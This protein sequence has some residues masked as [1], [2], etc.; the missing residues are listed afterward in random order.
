LSVNDLVYVLNKLQINEHLYD[1]LSIVYKSYG[2]FYPKNLE[3]AIKIIDKLQLDLKETLKQDIVSPSSPLLNHSFHPPKKRE[4]AVRRLITESKKEGRLEFFRNLAKHAAK[5][6]VIDN[7]PFENHETALYVA[8]K[9]SQFAKAII[10]LEEGATDI[11]SSSGDKPSMLANRIA[12]SIYTPE[13]VKLT[14]LF[15]FQ[16]EGIE[17][18][19]KMSMMLS[20]RDY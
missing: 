1:T 18:A 19:K 2:N 7:T 15:H 12:K 4:K 16:E 20:S 8:I 3:S 5:E 13:L 14:R 9:S 10:L 6:N 17:S 11:Q